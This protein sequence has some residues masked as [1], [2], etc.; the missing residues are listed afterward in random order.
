M[1]VYTGPYARFALAE[2]TSLSSLALELQPEVLPEMTESFT[3]RA[4]R[5]YP[6]T[7]RSVIDDGV[8][9]VEGGRITF[10]G[11]WPEYNLTFRRHDELPYFDGTIVPG[12]IDAHC[13]MTL[14]GDSRSY[15]E[16]ARDPDEM[17]ALAAVRNL[18]RH[19]SAGVTTLRDNGGRNRVVFVVREA[20]ARGYLTTPHLLLSGRPVTH[21]SGHFFW[22]NGV[23]DSSSEIRAVIREL[24]AEGA[25]HIKIMAS[26]GGTLGN[27][28]YYPSYTERELRIA[29]EIAHGLGRL[30]TAH[31]L[32]RDSMTN[33]VRAG[34]DCIEHGEFL[35]PG[36]SVQTARGIKASSIMEYDGRVVEELMEHGTFLSFT[37]QA[38]GYTTM[39]RLRIRQLDG[40]LTAQERDQ[41][42][43]FEEYFQRKA[44][45]FQK[46]IRDG[47]GERMVISTDAGPYD[48]PFGRLSDGLRLAVAAGLSPV[49][50]V[51]CVTALAA[52]AC[53]V[54]E[55]TGSLVAGKRADLLLVDGDPTRDITAIEAVRAVV[56]A[57]RHV[58]GDWA[59]R[60][61]GVPAVTPG[62]RAGQA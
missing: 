34:V 2:K 53:G 5:V 51:R 26:G 52:E 27:L 12:L 46:L 10:V 19:L 42:T 31:C 11:T 36:R 49:D 43:G 60:A 21:R 17:M 59:P 44:Q 14:S 28:P 45:I 6:G 13:H 3:V 39:E 23:A 8:V 1:A 29:V 18:Q 48:V 24:I 9:V 40:N 56:L 38:G 35:V 61:L 32:A 54:G 62:V 47:V 58:A 37:F 4:N 15:E 22:C 41:L 16:M 50:A 55:E 20:A 57:G 30:T 25:D 7:D 33:A